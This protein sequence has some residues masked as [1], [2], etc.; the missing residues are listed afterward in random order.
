MYIKVI[1]HIIK[2]TKPAKLVLIIVWKST[3][4]NTD[5]I[6]LI[7]AIVIPATTNGR[8]SKIAKLSNPTIILLLSFIISDLMHLH[9][10]SYE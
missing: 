10:T 9:D 1:I 3:P 6:P 7:N 5:T 2:N 8:N 4:V